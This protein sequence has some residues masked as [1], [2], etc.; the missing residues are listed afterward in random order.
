[1][2]VFTYRCNYAITYY[3]LQ[4]TILVAVSDIAYQ[5]VNLPNIWLVM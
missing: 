3:M 5:S 2:L 4:R 1:M